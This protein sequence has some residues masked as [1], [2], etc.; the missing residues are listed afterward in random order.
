MP[1]KE[2]AFTS[3]SNYYAFSSSEGGVKTGFTPAWKT[4]IS[5]KTHMTGSNQLVQDG[6]WVRWSQQVPPTYCVKGASR[7]GHGEENPP[8]S[9]DPLSL[10]GETWMTAR[11]E[12]KSEGDLPPRLWCEKT[13]PQ[14]SNQEVSQ[15]P[16]KKNRKKSTPECIKTK[17]VQNQWKRET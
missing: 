2:N 15:T 17:T 1:L 4:K 12:S 7:T 6:K 3:L 10:T 9:T 13:T 16:C 11:T 8:T 5:F 14:S